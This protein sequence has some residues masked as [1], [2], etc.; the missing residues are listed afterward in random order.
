MMKIS[1][2][3]IRR[4]KIPSVRG[5]RP[6]ETQWWRSMFSG[7]EHNFQHSQTDGIDYFVSGAAGQLRSGRPDEFKKANTIS[8]SASNHFLLITIEGKE[9]RI[10]AVGGIENNELKD[11][12]RSGVDMNELVDP[13]TLHIE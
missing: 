6:T 9:V 2:T 11:I 3:S 7:H 4:E 12:Q 10:R 5:S 8:W 13:I 1:S